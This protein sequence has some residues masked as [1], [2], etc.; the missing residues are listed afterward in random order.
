MLYRGAKILILDEPTA[1][2]V[3]QEV[4]ALFHNIRELK[5]SGSTILFIDHKLD[6]VL[7]IAD[8]ITVLRQGQSVATVKPADVTAH[9]LAELMVGSELPT[10]ATT[11]SDSHRCRRCWRSTTVVV[12]ELDRAV[13]SDFSVVVHR[14]EVVGIAGV[15][16]N[17]QSELVDAI[18]GTGASASGTI[19]MLGE[20]I[21]HSPVRYRREHGIGY[22]P[23]DRQREGLLLHAPLWENAALGH[24]TQAPFSNGFWMDRDG[25]RDRHRAHSRG[26]RRPHAQHRRRRP[27]LVGRQ[28]AE[29]DR[30]PRDVGQP[31]AADRLAPDPRHR[32]RRAGRRVGSI[33]SAPRAAGLAT[34]LISADLDE[35]I[36]LSDTIVVML[37]GR[38]V[39]TL[40]PATVTPRD[41]GAY[42]TGAALQA[43]AS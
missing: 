5:A 38:L 42:M 3:P 34:L 18:I 19:K 28:P 29:A 33:T 31:D 13:V 9:D 36:G 16:G 8:T 39:A 43:G 14:G 30:R 2:L 15:E 40:D 27:R 25:M 24:Q 12:N 37:R 26:V 11:E 23:Q 21:T 22:I 17:G 1:V 10:P 32:R 6:E 35:L 20:D 4:E 41:L 7:A